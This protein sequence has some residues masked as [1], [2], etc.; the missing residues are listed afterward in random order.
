MSLDASPSLDE[1]RAGSPPGADG[2]SPEALPYVAP[3]Y[4]ADG[5][6]FYHVL[7]G[8]VPGHQI[9][10]MYLPDVP[11]GALRQTHVGH[12]A[13]LIKYIEPRDSAAYAFAI[14]NLSRDDVQHN[15]G[16]GGL[17]I[18]FA[19]RVPGVVDHAG[20]DTP[21]YAHAVIAVDRH[22]DYTTLLEATTTLYRRFLEREG[23]ED[24]RGDFYRSYVRTVRQSP[25]HVPD[26]LARAIAEHDDLPSP[27][28]SSLNWDYAVD[29]GDPPQQ[30]AIVHDEPMDFGTLAHWASTLGALLYRSNIKWTTVSTGREMDI[31]GGTSI[32]FVPRSDVQA[33]MGGS[34]FELDDLPDDDDALAKLLFGA[35]RRGVAAPAPTQG[36]REAMA[37]QR[38]VRSEP[39]PPPDQGISV[40]VEVDDAAATIPVA[41]PF[42]AS[43]AFDPRRSS[44]VG[45]QSAPQLAAPGQAGAPQPEPPFP[46]AAIAQVG[47]FELGGGGPKTNSSA[48]IPPSTFATGAAHDRASSRPPRGAPR[49][50]GKLVIAGAV[51]AAL[52]VVIVVAVAVGMGASEGSASSS[53]GAGT[54]SSE[55]QSA[56]TSG[57]ATP[58]PTP[59]IPQASTTAPAPTA[60]SSASSATTTTGGAPTK[61]PSA[62]TSTAT[63]TS[64]PPTK[65]KP[66]VF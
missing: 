47:H 63:R 32:R 8:N 60:P 15:P 5:A 12:L 11:Q 36:W 2:P 62:P 41:S 64:K 25:A 49:Q 7:H 56:T 51:L 65:L 6:A 37:A 19:L 9:D 27:R 23:A 18:L 40:D 59:T 55:G 4:R 21:P 53:Q 66:P 46:G 13:R 1:G 58:A 22:L 20:R 50:R 48:A 38:G 16:H 31:A 52:A 24:R 42:D 61:A 57:G 26:F 35:K 30:I 54:S 39:P 28:K 3:R 33:G 29:G 44:P 10:F 45:G 17:A 34:T 43:R 14:G